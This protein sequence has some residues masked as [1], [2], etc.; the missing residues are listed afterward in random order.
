MDSKMR[1][2][3]RVENYVKYRPSYPKAAVDF[4]YGELG[5]NANSTIADIGSGTGIFT[6]LLLEHGSNVHYDTEIYYGE[7]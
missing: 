6:Q 3:D 7:A 1:F 2:S 4:L 5:F